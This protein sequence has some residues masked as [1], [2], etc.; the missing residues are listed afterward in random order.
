MERLNNSTFAYQ[1][2]LRNELGAIYTPGILQVSFLKPDGS[3]DVLTLNGSDALDSCLTALSTG[4]F[5]VD[6]VVDQIGEWRINERWTDDNWLHP[7]K[8]RQMYLTVTDDPQAWV[9]NLS[10]GSIQRVYFGVGVAG[11]TSVSTLQYNDLNSSLPFT[12]TTLAPTAEKAYVS[13]PVAWGAAHLYVDGLD[14]TSAFARS[15]ITVGAT[16][17]YLYEST[18]LLTTTGLEIEARP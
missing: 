4:V 5:R 1:F 18:Q 9:D 15:T 7:I 13:F 16:N 3:E 8:G 12:T 17:Y 2:T 6:Y 14:Q 11:L 10:P